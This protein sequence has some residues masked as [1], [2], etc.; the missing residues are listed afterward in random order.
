MNIY[1]ARWNNAVKI[2]EKINGYLAQ[3][4]IIFD[5]E[6]EMVEFPFEI[7]EDSEIADCNGIFRKIGEGCVLM[8]FLKDMEADNG[9]YDKIADYNAPFKK[10]KIIDP[11]FT[12][13]LF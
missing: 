1:D 7:R 8:H 4:F 2:A 11:R 12:K 5:E 3:G 9:Y 13:S 6:N 10:W